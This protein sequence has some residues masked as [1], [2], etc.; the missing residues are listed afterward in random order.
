MILFKLVIKKKKTGD[1]EE[2]V[3]GRIVDPWVVV[4]TSDASLQID[5]LTRNFFR[6]QFAGMWQPTVWNT[7]NHTLLP[8]RFEIFRLGYRPWILDPLDDLGHGYEIDVIVIREHLVHPEEERVKE[9]RIVLQPRGVEVQTERGAILFVVAVEVVIQKVVELVAGEDVR[10]RVDHSTTGQVFIVVGILPPV[11]LVQNHF[12]YSVAS[13]RAAL[14]I[15]VATVWH[16]EVH[17]VRP[18]WW[19]VQ[20]CRDG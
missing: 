16:T 7:F 10:T 5:G 19:V 14:Q 12:P 17:G 3:S 8:P 18:Q 13:G 20:W 15:A 9:F 11:Q 2:T 4:R 1:L 6:R